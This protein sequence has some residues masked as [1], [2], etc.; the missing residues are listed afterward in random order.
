M[1]YL[2]RQDAS[3]AAKCDDLENRLQHNNIRLYGIIKGVGKNAMLAFI[4]DFLHSALDLQAKLDIKIERAHRALAPNPQDAA[5]P[6][7]SI[8]V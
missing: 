3:L 5:A 4:T 1:G 8:I 6:L 2:L 7:R